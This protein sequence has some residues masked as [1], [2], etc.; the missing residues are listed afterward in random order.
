WRVY[1]AARRVIPHGEGEKD[2]QRTAPDRPPLH[3]DGHRPRRLH[4]R[5]EEGPRQQRRSRRNN[6]KGRTRR[7]EHDASPRSLI[8]RVAH[9]LR[10]GLHFEGGTWLP[11]G[12]NN[13]DTEE[14]EKDK[15]SGA[16]TRSTHASRHTRNPGRFIFCCNTSNAGV[17][18][19]Q[20]H[21][22]PA[23]KASTAAQI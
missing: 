10:F 4:H 2:P 21:P 14:E 5:Q 3:G 11:T 8:D 12:G 9:T 15:F 23:K 17:L 6:G 13:S 20:A 22:S 16:A 19:F 18:P 1:C 7:L